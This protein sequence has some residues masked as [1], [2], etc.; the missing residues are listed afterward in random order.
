M[1][2]STIALHAQQTIPTDTAGKR[3]IQIL[4][5]DRL[6]Y[7]KTSDSS[8]LQ[9][10]GGNVMVKQED[11]FFYCDSAVIN[12]LLNI[13]QAFG[14]VH[15]N[16]NDSINTYSNY[17]KYL[18]KEKKAYLKDNVKLTDGKGVLTT[19][20][21]EYD[22]AT[23]IGVYTKGGKLVSGKTVL[24]SKEGVYYGETKDT[25]FKKKVVLVDP[26]YTIKTDTLLYNSF[27]DK[28]T[29]IVPTIITSGTS[30]KILTSD[31]YYDL[32]NKKAYFG[33]RPIIQD[34]TTTLIADEVASDDSTGFGEARGNVVYTDTAQ[35]TML[36][37]NNLKTNKKEGSYLA[38]EK[39]V[40][41]IK[42][43]KDSLFIAADT[44]FSA[45]LSSLPKDSSSLA[46]NVPV[47][48]NADSSKDRYIE[49]YYH[50]RI[51]SDSLQAIGDSLF[52]SAQDSAFRL[53]KNPIV[54]AQENQITGDT[55]YLYTQNKKP[56]RMYVFENALAISKA[57]EG[58][59]NQVKGRTINGYFKEGNIDNLRA[60]GN[61]ESVYYGEDE[62]KKFV[63]VN[64][65]A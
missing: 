43:D 28:T 57:S 19:S 53:F 16:D 45:K 54:W 60:K 63:G 41:A 7:E 36:T 50:V 34:S 59:F 17:L 56:K 12:K 26:D 10:L 8:E 23:K 51:F 29:F 49:A 52:Y 47:V 24:T 3:Q 18:G 22:V 33:K 25:Y 5:A 64:K 65:S 48:N 62:R 21:L 4:H 6:N 31:G 44:L 27:Y 30:T 32:K 13:L 2:A 42:Q 46:S 35:G 14:H 1:L 61:A 38:T 9:S 11:T 15:I 37:S 58:Y 55:I 20:E 40:M 39:P